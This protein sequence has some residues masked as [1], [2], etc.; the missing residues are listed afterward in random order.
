MAGSA[1]DLTEGWDFSKKRDRREARQLVSSEDPHLLILSP[2]CTVFSRLRSL[3]T[4]KRDPAVVQREYQRAKVHLKF[5]C[6]LALMQ[7]YRGRGFLFEHPLGA[8][9]WREPELQRLA[10]VPGIFRL[11][12]DM[13]AYGL[14]IQ[15]HSGPRWTAIGFF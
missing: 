2:P 4:I 13:C 5:S 1:L 14:R 12:V 7:H 8:D 6:E 9:S 11:V 10:S 3:S 15:G